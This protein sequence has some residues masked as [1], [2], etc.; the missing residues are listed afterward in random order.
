M[1][2]A[3]LHN[4]YQHRGGEDTVFEAEARLLEAC[5]HRVV[6]YAVH[7]DNV[8]GHSAFAL[9]TAAVYNHDTYTTLQRLFRTERPDIMHCHNTLPLISPSAYFAANDAG[10]PVVQTLHNYRVL[11]PNAL[12]FRDGHVCEDCLGKTFAFPAIVHKCYRGSRAASAAVAGM[13]AFHTLAG[14]WAKRVDKYIALT[15]FAKGKFVE[16]GLPQEKIVVRPN[17]VEQDAG[18]VDAPNVRN[19]VLFVGRISPEK[20][21]MTALRAW[22]IVEK[23]K[24]IQAEFH[25]IGDGP[26]EHAAREFVAVEDLHSVRFLGRK[27]LADVLQA[28]QHARV[29]VFPSMLYETFGKSMIEAFSCG[30]PV[31]ASRLGALA[32]VV[33]DGRTGFLVPVGDAAALAKR[34][35]EVWSMPHTNYAAMRRAARAEYEAKYTAATVMQQLEH[36]YA[37]LL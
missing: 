24:G 2:I 28:M 14:T 19:Y 25:I 1:T 4:Y 9:A 21:I 27:T 3:L 30:T 17:F 35:E 36:I 13:N 5:G 18:F 20:G 16:G 6:R 22:R 12:F 29:L 8:K 37:S 23:E 33:A 10:V 15:E 11:C 34:I 32:E 31:I 26:E 7:N